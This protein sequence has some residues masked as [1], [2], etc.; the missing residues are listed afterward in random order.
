MT[1][2]I[3]VLNAGSSSLKFSVFN[4]LDD[5]LDLIVRGQIDGILSA[6]RFVAKDSK[7]VLL[8]E[9]RWDAV[10]VEEAHEKAFDVLARWLREQIAGTEIL[11]VGHRV[12]HGG[13]EF[14]E[15]VLIDAKVIDA[16][17]SLIPL[18]PLHQP[19]NLAPIRA[20]I[21]KR[22]ELPQVACFDTAFHRGHPKVADRFGLPDE[23]YRSGI[24]RYGFHGLSY[25]YIA[26]L[27][28]EI[29]PSIARG[30]V[31]V[32]HLGSGA[33]MC[34]LKDGKSIETTMGFSALDGLPMGTR[35]GSLDP[36]VLLYLIRE[37]SMDAD[38][39]ER[40]L[41]K[42]S[43]L[44]GVSG[45]S[46]DLRDLL[47]SPEPGAEQAIEY[48]VY[49][50][51]QELGALTATLGGLDALVFTAGIGENSAEIRGRVCRGAAWLGVTLDEEANQ[52]GRRLISSPGASP[53]VWV[54]PTN[55]ERM[56]ARHTLRVVDAGRTR[57]VRAV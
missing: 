50:I 38:A 11:A 55:E 3:L 49:R 41:Y 25:E 46:N 21:R 24:R 18:V 34:A 16:L 44:L 22:P 29:A 12:A 19:H 14:C 51:G 5:S 35:C 6:P 8:T 33:S 39:L 56:I 40:L 20:I 42:E 57:E 4:A 32:A 30:R 47:K 2:L 10:P 37:K 36:G 26:C 17:A 7:G 43:G 48:F 54:L 23:L 28:R 31:V 52:S 13:P 27:L 15:P 53:E 1:G 9:N 45:I